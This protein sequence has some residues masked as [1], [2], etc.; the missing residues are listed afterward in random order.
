LLFALGALALMAVAAYTAAPWWHY[1]LYGSV[2]LW[3][4]FGLC[5]LWVLAG[6]TGGAAPLIQSLLVLAAGVGA[7]VESRIRLLG[8]LPPFPLEHLTASAGS[9]SAMTAALAVLPLGWQGLRQRGLMPQ[10]L[11]AGGIVAA[12]AAAAPWLRHAS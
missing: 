1:G 5:L 4:S 6:R 9:I 3:T 10:I 2:V 12:V 8:A 7:L 11:A